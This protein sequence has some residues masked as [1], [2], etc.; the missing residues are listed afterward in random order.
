[1]LDGSGMLS[2]KFTKWETT[3]CFVAGVSVFQVASLFYLDS[4]FPYIPSSTSVWVRV[5]EA[6]L[7]PWLPLARKSGR[8]RLAVFQRKWL[9]WPLT[10]A[11]R[12]LVEAR[13]K[14]TFSY[15]GMGPAI[16]Y[17]DIE[18]GTT[19]KIPLLY[20]KPRMPGY[21]R[22]VAISDTHLL[23][24]D[25]ILP[26]G[27][28]LIHCGDILVEDRGLKGSEK[29]G[30]N[31]WR[32]LLGGFNQWLGA[33]RKR[34]SF[35]K[36][37][38]VTGGNHDQVLQELES[39]KIQ[40]MLSNATFVNNEHITI[41]CGSKKSQRVHLCAASRGYWNVMGCGGGGNVAFQYNTDQ[42]AE[43][44]LSLTPT[45]GVIDVLVTHGPPRGILDGPGK[46]AG[47][48]ILLQ[49]VQQRIKPKVHVFGHWHAN[50]G[51]TKIED[52]TFINASTI[53]FDYTISHLPIV[54][55]LPIE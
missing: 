27:D 49:H 43:E 8:F 52:T 25:V 31:R 32:T 55:D 5:S 26:S 4:I 15:T 41:D 28:V 48:L 1:M 44:M 40:K 17:V 38:F 51:A 6:S 11:R 47:C 10:R 13:K 24:E 20:L 42:S 3:A 30:K 35:Q 39:S 36:G 34:G 54:F 45:D 23:H 50:P 21:V 2:N 12:L 7:I 14:L 37:I 16:S 53:D 46:N 22:Y 18:T 33:Q 29:R 9:Y 19:T